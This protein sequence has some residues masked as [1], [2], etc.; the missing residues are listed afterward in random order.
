MQGTVMYIPGGQRQ[1][2]WG[3]GGEKQGCLYSVRPQGTSSSSCPDLLSGHPGPISLGQCFY[4]LVAK[5]K[6]KGDYPL[7]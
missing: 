6:C 7:K 4:H 5:L 3:W 2:W 1:K